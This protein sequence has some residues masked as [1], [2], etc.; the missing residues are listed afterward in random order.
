MLIV[1]EHVIEERTRALGADTV[2]SV[3]PIADGGRVAQMHIDLEV[4]A[5]TDI[6]L[7]QHSAYT[8]SGYII[9]IPD[10]DT[11]EDDP[12]TYWDRQVPKTGGYGDTVDLSIDTPGDTGLTDE[13]GKINIT[14]LMGGFVPVQF[15]ERNKILHESDPLSVV[16]GA[17]AWRGKDRI[18]TTM[19]RPL[20]AARPSALMFAIGAPDWGTSYD[21]WDDSANEEQQWIP[22]NDTDWEALRRPQWV[23]NTWV[24]QALGMTLRAPADPIKQ[25]FRFAEQIHVHNDNSYADMHFQVAGKITY[26]YVSPD[27]EIQVIT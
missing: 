19:N 25:L 21:D 2:F 8:M 16:T 12:N 5:L 27:S 13:A 26:H 9:E 11:P 4:T 6:T 17:D 18:I 23:I 1:R 20:R 24:D 7:L 15:F 3:A 14:E 10:P 22:T